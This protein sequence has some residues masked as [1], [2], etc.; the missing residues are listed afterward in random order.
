M[1]Y[2]VDREEFSMRSTLPLR[3]KGNKWGEGDRR[4]LR[5]AKTSTIRIKT[6]Q[7]NL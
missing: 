5:N 4:K 6:K 1:G 7:T 2:K 3:M